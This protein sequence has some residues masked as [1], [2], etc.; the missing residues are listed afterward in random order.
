MGTEPGEP[1][2]ATGAAS[3][4]AAARAFVDE[5]AKAFGLGDATREL[6]VEE[7]DRL[8]K[9]RSSVRLQQL[10]RGVPVIA[11]ELVVNV[12][13]REDVL[14]ASGEVAPIDRLD[15]TPKVSAAAAEAT[16]VD[17]AAKAHR[18]VPRASLHA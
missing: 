18:D 6:R 11:G 13:A 8:T 7:T 4:P 2:P 9:G 15:V 12:D 5:N 17:V 10:H 14:S 1:I 16:A 3:A